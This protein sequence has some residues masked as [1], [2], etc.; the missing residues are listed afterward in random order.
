MFKENSIFGWNWN[1]F[2]KKLISTFNCFKKNNISEKEKENS[3][4]GDID[5]NIEIIP[6]SKETF[7][8]NESS[9]HLCLMC[10]TNPPEVILVPCGHKCLCNECSEQY[11]SSGKMKNCPYCREKIKSVLIKIID[12]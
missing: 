9:E 11:K 6:N 1:D 7:R 3:V 8:N 12:I 10:M 4:I 5:K 2:K